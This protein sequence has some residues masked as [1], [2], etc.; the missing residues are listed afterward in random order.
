MHN[1]LWDAES[2]SSSQLESSPR[3]EPLCESAVVHVR[4]AQLRLDR[5][6][7]RCNTWHVI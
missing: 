3:G 4:V 2:I 6:A 7:S 5:Q 1:P